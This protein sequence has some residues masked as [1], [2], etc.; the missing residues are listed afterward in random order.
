MSNKTEVFIK[1]IKE[2]EK[3]Q[4]T[5]ALKLRVKCALLDYIGVAL[6]GAKEQQ[7]KIA[8]LTDCLGEQGD[9]YP[10]GLPIRQSLNNAVFLNGLNGH[11]LDFD[12]GTNAGIIHLGSPI[13]S[14]LLALAQKY[15]FNGEQLLKAAVLGYET[16]FTMALT[17]QPAHKQRG[18]HATGTCGMLGIA[19]AVSKALVYD[20]AETKRAF[21]TAAV[22]ATG[23]LKVL[24]DS[25]ELKPYNVGKTALL[26][27]IATQMAKAGFEVPDDALSGAAGFLAQ[28]YGSEEVEFAPEIKV[29]E[30][31]GAALEV[32][33]GE[34]V[35]DILKKRLEHMKN[36]YSD[37]LEIEEPAKEGDLLK[38]S[39]E[40]D[41]VLPEDASASLRRS[42]K[43]DESWI[44]LN[45]PEQFPGVI[46]ALTGAVKGGEYTF[47]AEFPADWRE[48]GLQGKSVSY[49]VKVHEA[50]R[51][52][53][54]SDEAKLAEKLGL[55]NVGKMHEE[56]KKAAERE[57][58]AAR[59]EA[60]R[61]KALEYLLE[62]T[63]AFPLPKGVLASTTEREFSRIAERLVRK[64]EDVEKF[65]AEKEKHL[66]EAKRLAEEYLRK[67]FILR[68]IARDEKVEVSRAELDEQIHAMSHY[69]GY[70][71]A[72]VRKMLE[73]NGGMAEIQ[74]DILMSKTLDAVAAA[75]NAAS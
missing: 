5:S 2:T 40:S 24:E 26:G 29:P 34:S 22:S 44:W 31:K 42:V 23:T 33:A 53:P 48:S 71:E 70:K 63:E 57:A 16:S 60:L 64:E 52:V 68:R 41:F 9:V 8:V 50:Q 69:M 67:F 49:R 37:Y 47:T 7:D 43:A 13:F 39:Y 35:E 58:E 25:S 38:V 75:A 72:D 12:D 56:L 59:K 30:Y 74:A 45:Q 6:A 27:L 54:V 18:Y 3:E 4:L 11:A 46:A 32:P 10:I 51:K 66:E 61:T 21:S 14:V 15:D 1:K 17:I 55:E 20:A 36:L 62:K 65:K 73:R 19:M 28:M